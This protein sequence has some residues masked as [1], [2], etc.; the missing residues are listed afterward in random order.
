MTKFQPATPTR[1]VPSPEVKKPT[2]DANTSS[3]AKLS[4]VIPKRKFLKAAPRTKILDTNPN[5][6]SSSS[7]LQEE[8]A[9]SSEERSATVENKASS[10]SESEQSSENTQIDANSAQN[11]G[12]NIEQLSTS[13]GQIPTKP[14]WEPKKSPHQRKL[15]ALKEKRRNPNL[16]LKREKVQSIP[17]EFKSTIELSSNSESPLNA[18]ESGHSLAPL[19]DSN[20][21]DVSQR[22]K[23][24]FFDLIPGRRIKSPAEILHKSDLYKDALK[25][26]EHL[27]DLLPRVLES[28]LSSLLKDDDALKTIKTYDVP[29]DAAVGL[30]WY[31]QVGFSY[32]QQSLRQKPDSTF[33]KDNEVA[34]PGTFESLVKACERGFAKL[35]PLPPGTE[36]FRGTNYLFDD[37]L[38]PG[39]VYTD[40]AFVST[41][42]LTKVAEQKFTGRF[43]LKFI[44]IPVDDPRWRDISTLTDNLSESEVLC[45]PNTS[46][47]VISREKTS[48][49][50]AVE[51]GGKVEMV[52]QE[53]ITLEPIGIN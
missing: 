30:R 9:T 52:N 6:S 3:S 14:R 49:Q 40:P 15:D 50:V 1:R 39:D 48:K 41:S 23:K 51:V 45:L 32:V 17:R 53:F 31:G 22:P 10:L 25:G 11:T 13:G 47:R 33:G 44:D 43:L 35:P 20:Q 18:T 37:S 27:V 24:T 16:Q 36:L 29:F 12:V 7:T 38:K 28:Y 8:S 42:K 34:P 21:H 46:F 2:G 19:T 26:G 5:R 4:T